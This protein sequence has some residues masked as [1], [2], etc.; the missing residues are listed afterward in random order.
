MEGL[1]DTGGGGHSAPAWRLGI[2]SQ[3]GAAVE[4]LSRLAEADKENAP[5]YRVVAAVMEKQAGVEEEALQRLRESG[6]AEAVAKAARRAS[7]ARAPVLE[8]LGGLPGP[9]RDEEWL[10]E[11]LL[12]LARAAMEAGWSPSA[13]AAGITEPVEKALIS[14]DELLGDVLRGRLDLV[15]AWAG[16]VSAP[17]DEVAALVYWLLQPLLSATRLAAGPALGWLHS[18][19]QQGRCPVCGAP[20]AVGYMAGEGRRQVMHCSIC[21]MEWVFPR[22][23]CPRCGAQ[24]PGD[25]VFYQPDEERPWLRLYRCRRCGAS[26]RIVDEEHPGAAREGLPPRLLYDLYTAHLA[27]LA[28]KLAA[29][30]GQ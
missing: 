27:V 22:A 6:A 14:L 1:E 2:A 15:D 29:G 18:Y 23:T 28:E 9:L 26:W 25:V 12:E 30:G 5:V 21:H 24:S 4:W 17:R 11:K 10:R 7:I 3:A 8:V 13:R 20:A 16:A 19:W